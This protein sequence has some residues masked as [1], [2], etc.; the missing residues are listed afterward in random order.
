MI[1][2]VHVHTETHDIIQFAVLSYLLKTVPIKLIT[3]HYLGLHITMLQENY[4][5]GA[6][7][8]EES[9]KTNVILQYRLLASILSA[10]CS[11]IQQ[12]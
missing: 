9:N 7:L 10:V 1:S 5:A 3:E 6:S 4:I 2:T 8:R 12:S 11:V